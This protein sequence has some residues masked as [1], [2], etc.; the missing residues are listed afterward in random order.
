MTVLDMN[1]DLLAVPLDC[2][3]FKGTLRINKA[4]ADIVEMLNNVTTEEM[5]I[6][7]MSQKYGVE[8]GEVRE[9]VEKVLSTLREKGL[10]IENSLS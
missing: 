6:H 10:L 4:A 7:A 8:E 9:K 3:V 1:G 2:S 5:I